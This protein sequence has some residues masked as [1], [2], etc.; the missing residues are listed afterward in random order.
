MAPEDTRVADPFECVSLHT[1]G[2]FIHLIR[3]KSLEMEKSSQIVAGP[4]L[5]PRVFE[6]RRVMEA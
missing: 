3:V 4:N 6:T 5:L 1:K 2:D